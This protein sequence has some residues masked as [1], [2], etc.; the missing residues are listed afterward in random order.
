[1]EYITEKAKSG[2]IIEFYTTWAGEEELGIDSYLDVDLT[3]ENSIS[4]LKI[5]NR[6]L[7]RFKKGKA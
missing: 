3:D 1:M 5:K 6:Q 2:E 4:N 7:I